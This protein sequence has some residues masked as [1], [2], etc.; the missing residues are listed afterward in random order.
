M[1]NYKLLVLMLLVTSL[2]LSSAVIAQTKKKRSSVKRKPIVQKTMP[3]KKP[4]DENPLESNPAPPPA[5]VEKPGSSDFKILLEGAYSKVETPFVFVA[6]DAETYALI[7]G[8]VN[9]GLPASS[10]VDFSRAAVVAA[11]AGEKNTGGWSVAI[12]Q[13][14]NKTIVDVRAPGKGAMVTQALTTPFQVAVVPIAAELALS[15]ELPAAWNDKWKM[16]RVSNGDFEYSGGIR[17]ITKK[18]KAEGTIGVLSY[19]D[20]ITY[21]FNLAGKGS[22]K[23]LKLSDTVSGIIN[24]GN[25]EIARLD[26][27]TFAEIPRSALKVSGTTTVANKLSLVFEP[28]PPTIADSFSVTGKIEAAKSSEK[29]KVKSEK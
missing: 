18:F 10:T 14:A 21:N 29:L 6:R 22:S 8:M 12:R 16:Y 7:R 2:F 5:P 1:K 11:F 4:I 3:E 24:A 25:V 26:A 15:L 20:Y 9:E 13:S 27:G 17:G 23:A 28:L 19:K